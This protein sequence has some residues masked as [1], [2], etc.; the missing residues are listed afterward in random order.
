MLTGRNS[1]LAAPGDLGSAEIDRDAID[2]RSYFDI[3]GMARNGKPQRGKQGQTAWTILSKADIPEFEHD[4]CPSLAW[5]TWHG[6]Y[7][8]TC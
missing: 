8:A 6:N 2:F 3:I 5:A 7:Y 1:H 4:S